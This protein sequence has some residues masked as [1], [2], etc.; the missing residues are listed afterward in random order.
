MLNFVDK[1]LTAAAGRERGTSFEGFF[2]FFFFIHS[3]CVSFQMYA[4]PDVAE[5]C[6]VLLHL[7]KSSLSVPES[8]RQQAK[9]LI[10]KY[11]ASAAALKA[12]QRFLC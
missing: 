6:L 9:A 2:F 12:S 11:G 4:H 5:C 1:S 3:F 10:Q 7:S 8:L